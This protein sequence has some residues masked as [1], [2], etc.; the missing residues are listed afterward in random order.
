[1]QTLSKAASCQAS[2]QKLYANIEGQ[3]RRYLG[4]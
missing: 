2:Q 1:M 3:V 4:Y